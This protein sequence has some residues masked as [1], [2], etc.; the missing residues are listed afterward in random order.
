MNA[1]VNDYDDYHIKLLW[2]CNKFFFMD[3]TF[4]CTTIYNKYNNNNNNNNINNNN[5]YFYRNVKENSHMK[6]IIINNLKVIFQMQLCWTFFHS[7]SHYFIHS[8]M[9]SCFSYIY[10]MCM[11]D[12]KS[13]DDFLYSQ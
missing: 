13:K 4:L 9:R 3:G 12:D 2:E 11:C 1:I 5:N 6:L 10:S 7:Y 8:F